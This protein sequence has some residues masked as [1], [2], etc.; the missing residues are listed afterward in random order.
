MQA[1]RR[2]GIDSMALRLYHWTSAAAAQDILRDGFRDATHRY[3][4]DREFSGVWLSE[5]PDANNGDP[6]ADV[7]LEV[8]LAL[9]A[10][11][12]A[13]YEWVEDGKPYREWLIPAAVLNANARIALA[14]E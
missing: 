7:L 6:G 14:T 2:Q 8:N 4:A 13:D 3:L 9:G 1:S 11:A 10:E 5:V 12:I